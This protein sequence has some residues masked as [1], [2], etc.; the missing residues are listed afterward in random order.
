MH[1]LGI[2][3][4]PGEINNMFGMKEKAEPGHL[5]KYIFSAL[6]FCGSKGLSEATGW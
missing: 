5:F 1:L 2:E 6:N 4:L 3:F